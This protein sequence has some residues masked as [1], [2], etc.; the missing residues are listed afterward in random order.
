MAKIL[1]ISDAAFI[2]LHGVILVARSENNFNVR[3]I[4]EETGMSRH[5]VAKVMQR[6]V[7]DNILT[8]SR[9][10]N[11]GFVLKRKPEEITFLEIFESIE[12]K[13]EVADCPLDKKICKFGLCIFNNITSKMT[14][15]F[16]NYLAEQTL[17][18]Y[19]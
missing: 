6:L 17:D 15:Q 4:A 7:K 12:G 14:L 5:H 2:A 1:T 16:K 13:I 8:S 9:G 11:G 3:H 18:K 10:P 19:L